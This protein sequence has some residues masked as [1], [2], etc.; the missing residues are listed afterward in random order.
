MQHPPP[1]RHSGDDGRGH[2]RAGADDT[3]A[4]RNVRKAKPWFGQSCEETGMTTIEAK[5]AEWGEAI[6]LAM[7]EL[8][9]LRVA[10]QWNSPSPQAALAD[11]EMKLEIECAMDELDA[12]ANAAEL[13]ERLIPKLDEEAYDLLTRAVEALTTI[14]WATRTEFLAQGVE[15]V[16][17]LRAEQT[18]SAN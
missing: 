13:L 3:V 7:R 4:H 15:G 16:R 11:E 5:S 14:D 18:G 8:C 2:G 10:M 12:M 17:R 6:D 9:H 1:V